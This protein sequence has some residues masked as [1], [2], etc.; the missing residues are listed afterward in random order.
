MEYKHPLDRV[1]STREDA[2]K[3]VK[4]YFDSGYIKGWF[5]CPKIVGGIRV[6]KIAYYLTNLFHDEEFEFE[7]GD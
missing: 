3:V 2:M 5:I 1:Y 4:N 7:T 6:Y